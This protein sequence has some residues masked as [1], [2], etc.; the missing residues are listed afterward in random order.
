MQ[1]DPLVCVDDAIKACELIAQF[2]Q[3]M[4]E[5]TFMTMPR[6]KLQ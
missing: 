6:L 3:G 5:K 1:H 4:K 2:I